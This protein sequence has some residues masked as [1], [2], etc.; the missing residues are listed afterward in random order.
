MVFLSGV[1]FSL[2]GLHPYIRAL[3]QLFPLTQIT[4]A[5]RAIMID[6][7]GLADISHRLLALVLMSFVFLAVGSYGF[8]WE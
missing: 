6:G 1:W 5:S 8:R 3:A 2:E 4:E 7:A